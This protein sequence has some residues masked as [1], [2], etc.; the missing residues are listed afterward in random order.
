MYGILVHDTYMYIWCVSICVYIYISIYMCMYI[1]ICNYVYNAVCNWESSICH[2][3][4]TLRNK[5]IHKRNT[6]WI[7]SLGETSWQ[8]YSC[9]SWILHKCVWLFPWKNLLLYIITAGCNHFISII[10]IY[11][12]RVSSQQQAEGKHQTALPVPVVP[13]IGKGRCNDAAASC[14]KA[15]MAASWY[16][17]DIN[18]S[19][20]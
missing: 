7:A 9:S 17:H 13:W 14:N 19:F 16:K 5:D 2:E 20:T 10:Y 1:Y 8:I 12:L 6:N 4:G 15:N 18:T 3:A 11:I